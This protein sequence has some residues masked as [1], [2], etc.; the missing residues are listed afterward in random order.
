M[1]IQL[2][3]HF[4]Y[5]KL[6][7]FVFPSVAMMVFGSVYGIVDGLFV[8]NIVGKTPFAALNLIYPFIAVLSALG[9]MIGAGGNAIVSKTLGE[10]EKEKANQYFSMLIYVS[11]VLGIAI[12]VLGI[13]TVRPVSILLGAEGEEMIENCVVYGSIIFAGIPFFMLQNAFQIFF[14]TA[15]RPNYG[16]YVTVAAGCG[17]MFLD[18]LFMAVFEWGISGAA[19]ATISSQFIGAVIPVV[20][21][22]RKHNSSLLR[23]GKGPFVWKVFWKTCTNGSSEFVTNVSGNIV[24]MLYNFQLMRFAGENGVAAYG[25]LMYANWIFVAILFGYVTGASPIIGYHYGAQN[26]GELKNLFKK[27]MVLMTLGGIALTGLIVLSADLLSGIFVGY[28]AVLFE[29]TKRAV[30][31]SAFAFLICGINIFGSGFFTAL[32]NGLIS[33][34]ISFLRT[35]VFQVAAVM[36]LP[37]F[38]EIDGIWWSMVVSELLSFMVTIFCLIKY[39]NRYHYV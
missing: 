33:A 30:L 35:V 2:C 19:L 39:K 11:L 15:E 3:E 24:A 34:V 4:D 25:V 28:D 13:T 10:G 26:H 38:W 16:F 1:R 12:A 22:L 23:L 14:I 17:N 5:K 21:F 7:R 36:I 32:N 6:L 31:I 37:I 20:Y 18:W 27:S 9:F 29:M 8:S